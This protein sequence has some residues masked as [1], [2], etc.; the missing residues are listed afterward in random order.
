M[1]WERR[2]QWK[3][4]TEVQVFPSL[5]Q[6]NS[7]VKYQEQH[8]AFNG[9]MIFASGKAMEFFGFRNVCHMSHSCHLWHIFGRKETDR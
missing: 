1:K 7:F 4:S 6:A 8:Q 9:I 2:T 5:P 3:V